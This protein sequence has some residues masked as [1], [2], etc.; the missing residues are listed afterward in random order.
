L[1]TTVMGLL[2]LTS[3]LTVRLAVI[4]CR[5]LMMAVQRRR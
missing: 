5:L 2:M 3:F 4:R 1:W